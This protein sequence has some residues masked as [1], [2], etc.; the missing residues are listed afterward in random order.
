VD[1]DSEEE[2]F[3][4]FTASQRL[5]ALKPIVWLHI[6]R[7]GT[8]FANVLI[9]HENICKI[10]ENETLPEGDFP[11]AD[12]FRKWGKRRTCPGGFSLPEVYPNPP[13]HLS[14]GPNYDKIKGHGVVVL[15]QPEQRVL[16]A[17]YND[18]M[19]VFVDHKLTA[20]EYA[21]IQQGCMVKMFTRE[22]H[23]NSGLDENSFGKE[24]PCLA[25]DTPSPPTDEEIA[26]ASY[27]LRTGF[28]FVGLADKFDLTV[29]LFHAMFGG[30]CP[31]FMFNDVR[32]PG[33]Q[34]QLYDT[35][36]LEGFV[37][38][39]DNALYQNAERIFNSNLQQFGVSES[40]CPSI[41]Q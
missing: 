33:K 9:H 23:M 10:P 18:H 12:F 32:T 5:E 15:R 29:C 3:T 21:E 27:R 19:G 6:P 24:G 25:I 20:R 41:C 34:R 38:Y 7:C 28:P 17:F 36:E 37:D 2:D 13:G 8:S 30:S 40:N 31:K 35:S 26:I 11:L 39:A 22:N 14:V 1:T 4:E 16:S